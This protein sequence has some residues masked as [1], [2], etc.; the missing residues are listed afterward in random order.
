MFRTLDVSTIPTLPALQSADVL[1]DD[2]ESSIHAGAYREAKR[3]LAAHR[4]RLAH[5]GADADAVCDAYE[6][7]LLVHAVKYEDARALVS[8]HGRAELAHALAG[9]TRALLALVHA[10]LAFASGDYPQA[11]ARYRAGLDELPAGGDGAD[12]GA[13][14]RRLHYGL[15][16]AFLFIHQP[17]LAEDAIERCRAALAGSA[18]RLI[19]GLSRRARAQLFHQRAE[20]D[21]ARRVGLD[22]LERL[23]PWPLERAITHNLVA[24]VANEL[25]DPE[26]RLQHRQAA[27]ASIE[28]TD[29]RR[30]LGR[31]H[32]NLGDTLVQSGRLDEAEKVLV[33]WDKKSRRY[34]NLFERG[35]HH[36]TVGE[37]EMLRG[38]FERATEL[39]ALAVDELETYP[40]LQGET[41]FLMAQPLA[42]SG[43]FD[44]ALACLARALELAER[45]QRG[46]LQRMARTAIAETRIAQGAIDE[47]QSALN[48]LSRIAEGT[49]SLP[50]TMHLLRVSGR[51]DA[52]RGEL[53]R[54]TVLLRRSRA[55]AFAMDA[56]AWS[57]RARIHVADV[58]ARRGD[59]A[60]AREA[61]DGAKT[62]LHALGIHAFDGEIAQVEASVGRASAAPPEPAAPPRDA[63]ATVLAAHVIE[64]LESGESSAQV[65]R[66]LANAL[67]D[68]DIPAR[69]ISSVDRPDD[70]VLAVGRAFVAVDH[71]PESLEAQA[72]LSLA[73]RLCSGGPSGAFRASQWTMPPLADLDLIYASDA[74]HG[75]VAQLTRL[76]ASSLPFL[77]TGESGVGK[78]LV[79]RA[80]H[81]LSS[82]AGG[83]F[84]PVSCASIPQ[85]LVASSL[86]GHKRGAFTGAD[87]DNP[88]LARA[89]AGGTLFLDEIGEVP[90]DVQAQLLRFLENGEV[91]AVGDTKPARVDVRVVAATHRDLEQMVRDQLFREDLYYRLHVLHV[92]V[93][94]LRERPNDVPPLVAAFLRDANAHHGTSVRIQDDAVALLA[95][96]PLPGNVRQLKHV[97]E[98]LVVAAGEPGVVL[99]SHV[100]SEL[101]AAP[102]RTAPPSAPPGALAIP[103]EP[104]ALHEVLAGV[105]REMIERALSRA[106][107]VSAA[108]KE[109][110]ISRSSL[111]DRM[112]RLGISRE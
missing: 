2:V 50:V 110:G 10:R 80:V 35:T 7:D 75:I 94:A 78:E 36:A 81:R 21:A 25:G 102:S 42:L 6:A 68:L 24:N 28:E 91:L 1:L 4:E 40:G 39:Y 44:E 47:A 8:R 67:G 46:S 98:R 53:E 29:N 66:S 61:L 79:A 41:L 106:G 105:E 111:Y 108:A 54:A 18:D 109:L 12:A 51:L 23:A 60:A 92:H 56:P 26:L 82:R 71:W 58:H 87:R 19:E 33:P 16:E 96:H 11:I 101:G 3:L 45:T 103:D 15:A 84:V 89:A 65:A 72:L 104:R 77:I 85:S 22:A 49:P 48:E 95:A 83:P 17:E 73:R 55:I 38:R 112:E 52:E 76:R 27:L 5:A 20:L 97:V 14:S 31:L 88:G 34:H 100:A 37:L 64:L 43:R 13:L 62:D 63:R 9:D 59:A 93:P 57:G 69:A 74:M 90:L 99:R 86:F 30:W 107:N 32:H 70:N